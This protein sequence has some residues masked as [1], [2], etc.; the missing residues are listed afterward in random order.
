M[1]G[2]GKTKRVPRPGVEPG[3]P[4]SMRGVIVRFTTRAKERKARESNPHDLAVARCSKP[5]RRAVSGCPPYPVGPAGV[6]PTWSIRQTGVVS[7]DHRPIAVRL[8]DV[9][10]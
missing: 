1:P 2:D 3:T 6:E 5:A 4:R 9:N 8:D 7:L 10:G